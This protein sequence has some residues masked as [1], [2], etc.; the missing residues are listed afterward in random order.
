MKIHIK[1]RK[2]LS[3]DASLIASVLNESFIEFESLYT[4][5]AFRATTHDKF[6][7]CITTD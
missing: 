6:G 7:V 2:A 1:I 3:E 5:E 4:P